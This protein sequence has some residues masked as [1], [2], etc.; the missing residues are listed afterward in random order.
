[1]NEVGGTYWKKQDAGEVLYKVI[2]PGVIELQKDTS[3]RYHVKQLAT[4]YFKSVN[5]ESMRVWGYTYSSPKEQL[6][7]SLY[8]RMTE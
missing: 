1:M 5:E 2:A 7:D 8:K 3:G 4:V 6:F